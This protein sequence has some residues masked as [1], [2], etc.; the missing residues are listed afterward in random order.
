MNHLMIDLETMGNKPNAAIVSIGAVFFEPATGK[1]GPQFSSSVQLESETELGASL[2]AETIMWWLQQSSEARAAIVSSSFPI[3]AVLTDLSR[4]VIEGRSA[5]NVQ[6]WG[7]GAT[8]D[9]VIL[10]SAYQR[11]QLPAFWPFWND[12]DVRTMVELGRQLGID[13]KR[14]MPFPG[15]RHNALDD[16]IHQAQYVSVIW[17]KLIPT[18]SEGVN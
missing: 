15:D 8:F 13:P 18:T 16:A 4:F 7:N 10:R 5:N 3:A 17:Q 6:V 9:N 1:I 12:R 14:D 11:T 2:D